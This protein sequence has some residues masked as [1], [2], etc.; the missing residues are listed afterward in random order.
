M[1]RDLPACHVGLTRQ[2]T[3]T[4]LSARG[5]IDIATVHLLHSA[6]REVKP[7]SELL[8]IDTPL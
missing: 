5:E 4:I 1:H 8:V 3:T 7:P 2:G 6:V